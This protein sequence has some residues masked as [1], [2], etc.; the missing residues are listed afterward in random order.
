[1]TYKTK[2]CEYLSKTHIHIYIYIYTKHKHIST[3]HTNMRRGD[4]G[5]ENIKMMMVFSVKKVR[6]DV[7]E[8]CE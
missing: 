2:S 6:F 3:P 5:V 8:S 7:C 4:A 1:M